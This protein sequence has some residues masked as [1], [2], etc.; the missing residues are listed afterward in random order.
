[1]YHFFW[2]DLGLWKDKNCSKSF[3]TIDINL[4]YHMG[5][6]WMLLLEWERWCS[7]PLTK[8]LYSFA[9]SPITISY[10]WNGILCYFRLRL[11]MLVALEGKFD[12]IFVNNSDVVSPKVSLWLRSRAG[13]NFG[14]LF[15]QTPSLSLTQAVTPYQFL[16]PYDIV[17]PWHESFEVGQIRLIL[18]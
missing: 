7:N 4:D 1:M 14:G 6:T 10:S 9:I 17:L 18:R 13:K 3:Y 16:G 2:D 15:P 11:L 12:F 5:L 8:S